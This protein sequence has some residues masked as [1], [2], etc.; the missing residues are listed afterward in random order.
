MKKICLFNLG[1]RLGRRLA[2]V[3]AGGQSLLLLTLRLV[4]GGQYIQTGHGKLMNLERT[5][6]FFTDL[7]IPAPGFHAVLVGSTEFF[8]G[9]LLVLGLGTRLVSVPLIISMIVAYL[10]AERAEAFKSLDSFTSAAPYQF[11]LACLILLHFGPG[12]LAIDAWFARQAQKR[13]AT[14][15]DACNH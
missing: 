1:A 13:L 12:K 3:A 4:Y 7:H 8:G 6:Q 11:L 10:T 5:T 14:A 15:P 9:I 2:P